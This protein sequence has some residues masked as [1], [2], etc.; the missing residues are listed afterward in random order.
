MAELHIV[1]HGQASLFAADYDVLS[2]LGH[3]Q[4]QRLGAHW[5][6]RGWVPDLVICGPAKRHGGTAAGAAAGFAAGAAAPPPAFA[7]PLVL[8]GLDEFDVFTLLQRVTPA[9]T[10]AD[11]PTRLAAAELAAQVDPGRRGG[12]LQRLLERVMT[13]WF[14]DELLAKLDGDAALEGIESWPAFHQRVHDAL[15]IALAEADARQARRAAIFTSVGP[16]AVALHTLVELP[17]H[18]AF[19]TAWRVRNASVTR[20][21]RAGDRVTLD[22]FNLV[23]HLP[24]PAEVT[25]R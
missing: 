10:A 1:R 7:E 24:D 12:A 4:A 19:E 22:Q 11:E 5:A 6:A 20:F 3:L 15:R 21:V 18:A 8:P 9:L 17:V 2:P 23:D 14:R 13:L 25:H 16:I